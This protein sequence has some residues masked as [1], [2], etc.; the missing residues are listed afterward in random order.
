MKNKSPLFV[1]YCFFLFSSLANSQ[2][3]TLTVT[4]EPYH[5]LVGGIQLVDTTWDDPGFIVPLGF[6]FDFFGETTNSLYSHEVFVGGLFTTNLDIDALNLI[7]AFS[8]DLID[9]GYDNGENLSPISYK[10]EGAAGVR[11]TTL[12]Y[13]NAGFYSGIV[14]NG[15]RQDYI[16]FQLKLYEMNGDIE[17]HIGPY[18]TSD[19]DLDFEGVPGPVIGLIQAFDFVNLEV[20][21]EVELLDGNALDPDIITSFVE[22]Y[23]TWPIPE[24]T[25]YRFS[26]NSTAIDETANFESESFYFPNPC[27]QFVTLKPELRDEVQSPVFV[28]NSTGQLVRIDDQPDQVEFHDLTAGIYQ[29]KFQASDCQVVQR[30]LVMK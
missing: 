16:N 20:N 24:N 17:I 11:V 14:T 26:G 25:V 10:T 19:P 2:S 8:V 23:V 27:N 7:L 6:N 1:M 13:N 12:E 30:I 28:T 15:I 22:S 21:G 29:L 3:Y 4:N 5:D 9:R 18:L